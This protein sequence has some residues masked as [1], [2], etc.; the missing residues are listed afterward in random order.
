MTPDEWKETL[1]EAIRE[2]ARSRNVAAPVVRTTLLDGEQFYLARVDASP[3][4]FLTLHPYPPGRD[5][6]MLHVEGE[7]LDM[8]PR[9]VI[10]PPAF[11][12]KIELL[13]EAAPEREALGFQVRAEDQQ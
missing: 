8:T 11:I 7:I 4:D 1:L 6:E 12:A 5:V 10:V 2:F 9:A 13:V 3:G